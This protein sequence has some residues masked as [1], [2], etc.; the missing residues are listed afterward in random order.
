MTSAS[1][2]P[3]RRS[4]RAPP[5]GGRRRRGGAPP[6]GRVVTSPPPP[7]AP[8]LAGVAADGRRVKV[9]RLVPGPRLATLSVPG[10]TPVGLAWAGNGRYLLASGS[11]RVLRWE[12][13]EPAA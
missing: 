7:A 12:F 10:T 8:L 3:R 4:R 9:W 6:G 2:P 1:P 13:A 11:D 5:T